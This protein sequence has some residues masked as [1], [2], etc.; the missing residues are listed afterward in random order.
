MTKIGE[1]DEG[2]AAVAD[3]ALVSFGVVQHQT[4]SR[5]LGRIRG[6][7]VVA[8]TIHISSVIF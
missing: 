4:V 5:T 7:G 2:G 6:D 1:D 3:A 8:V